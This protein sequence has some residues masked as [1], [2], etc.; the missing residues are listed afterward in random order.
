MATVEVAL[1]VVALAWPRPGLAGA[2]ACSYLLFGGYVV[3]ARRRRGPLASCGCFG[4]PDTPATALH[5]VVNLGFAAAAGAVAATGLRSSMPANLAAQPWHGVP[6]L[7]AAAATGWLVFLT[8][9]SLA[10][11]QAI[12]AQLRDGVQV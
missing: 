8:L 5:V 10:R 6:L 3:L 12:R 4:T 7:L 9:S 2:V 1:G 11:L